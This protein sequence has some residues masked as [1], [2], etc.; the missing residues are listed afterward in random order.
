MLAMGLGAWSSDAFPDSDEKPRE[1]GRHQRQDAPDDQMRQVSGQDKADKTDKT[2]KKP[3]PL[4][5]PPGDLFV[6]TRVA[7][8]PIFDRRPDGNLEV[9]VPITLSEAVGGANI[10]VPT[11]RGTKRIRVAPGT[12]HGTVQRLRGEGPP[13]PSS[14]DRGDIH[15]RLVVE[16]PTELDDRQR[17][18]LAELSRSGDGH[19][20]RE[21]ILAAARRGSG[22]SEGSGKVGA[23]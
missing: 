8:S 3:H 19:D 11:L 16:I 4:G 22:R 17:E 9:D 14:R 18:A 23:A 10:E 20:P 1:Q 6:T 21:R 13:K 5:G 15:Y 7:A 2:D 12:Q